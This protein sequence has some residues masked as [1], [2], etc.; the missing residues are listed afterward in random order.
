MWERLKDRLDAASSAEG[1]QLLKR[2]F[3]TTRPEVD[4][5]IG[6]YNSKPENLRFQLT[7]TPQEIMMKPFRIKFSAV[8]PMNSK[9]LLKL[10]MIRKIF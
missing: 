3:L 10:L 1:R 7:G 6:D 9:T 5:T 8:Y 4:K 2:K